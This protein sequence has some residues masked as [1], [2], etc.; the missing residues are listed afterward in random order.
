MDSGDGEL[1]DNEARGSNEY[2][3]RDEDA[4][5]EDG[6]DWFVKEA[7]DLMMMRDG[8]WRDDCVVKGWRRMMK[9]RW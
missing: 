1:C 7:G 9:R 3:V 4:W 8:D 2:D 5:H 6:D